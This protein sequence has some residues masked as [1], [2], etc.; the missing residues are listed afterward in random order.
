MTK[1]CLSLLL[2][3]VVYALAPPVNCQ[4]GNAERTT[5][6][7]VLQLITTPERFDRQLISVVGFLTL[8]QDNDALYL[9]QI[10]ALHVIVAN[11]VLIERNGQITRAGFK[12]RFRTFRLF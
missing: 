3:T 12:N 5:R 10:D 9:H 2:L 6:V 8:G 11:S 7:S 1:K 4:I